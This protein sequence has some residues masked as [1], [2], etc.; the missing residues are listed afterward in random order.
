MKQREKELY[1]DIAFRVAE[2]SRCNRKRVGCVIVKNNNIIS[3]GWNGTPAGDDNACEDCNN[4]TKPNVIHAE[5]NALRKLTRSN[6]SS[7]GATVFLTCAPCTRCS[8]RMSDAKIKKV[9][10]AE[11]YESSSHGLGLEYLEMHNVEIELL[12]K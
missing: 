1:M 10:Y 5:D 2:M 3:F 6:E 11:L 12:K 9:Y 7:D 4:S 8:E